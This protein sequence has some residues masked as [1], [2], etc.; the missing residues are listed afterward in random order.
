MGVVML[1]KGMVQ[2]R[3]K[4]FLK[5]LSSFHNLKLSDK[6]IEILNEFYW[7]SSGKITRESKKKVIDSIEGMTE[8]NLNNY[9]MKLK[10]RGMIKNSAITENIMINV[11]PGDRQFNLSFVFES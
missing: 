5:L 2:D 8:F 4:V 11:D 10:K 7:K 3:Y 6:E 9:L 1:K